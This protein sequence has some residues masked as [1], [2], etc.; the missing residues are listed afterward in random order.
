MYCIQIN[1]YSFRQAALDWLFPYMGSWFSSI[2]YEFDPP[3]PLSHREISSCSKEGGNS[4][5]KLKPAYRFIQCSPVHI[6]RY[7]TWIMRT[8][9]LVS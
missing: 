9:H 3:P 7:C 4:K 6:D 5:V 2:K 8:C 1:I